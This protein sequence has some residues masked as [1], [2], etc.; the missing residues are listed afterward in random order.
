MRRGR[1]PYPDLLT[2]REQEVLELLRHG[3]TNQQIADRLGISMYG[4]RYHVSEIL[5]KLG[6]SSRE[7]AAACSV[8]DQR[9]RPGFAFA[10]LGWKSTAIAGGAFTAVVAALVFSVLLFRDSSTE[11]GKV[12]FI[13]DGSLWVKALPDGPERQL[14][15][16][17]G[18]MNPQ[19]SP[20]GEWVL[21][22]QGPP[23][24]PEDIGVFVMRSDGSEQR[25]LESNMASWSPVSD[26]LAISLT[27]SSL[28]VE[29]ADGTG[30]RQVLPPVPGRDFNPLDRRLRP[31]WSS[32]GQWLVFEEHHAD[33][34]RAAT[35]LYIGLRAVRVDGSDEHEVF[36]IGITPEGYSDGPRPGLRD[37]ISDIGVPAFV[38]LASPPTTSPAEADGLP[39]ALMSVAAV[40]TLRPDAAGA[41]AE[42]ESHEGPGA[43]MLLFRDAFAVSSD[44]DA[45][46][47]VEGVKLL[48]T[49]ISGDRTA[50]ADAQTDKA[51][52][53]MDLQTGAVTRL[54]SEDIVAVSPQWSPDGEMLAFVAR[55]D[56]GPVE[57]AGL[58]GD[59]AAERNRRLWTIRSDGSRAAPLTVDGAD[60]RHERP[61][62]SRD[63]KQLLFACLTGP[64]AED[65]SLWVVPARGGAA[66]EVVEEV[67]LLIA[68]GP[69]PAFPSR[70]GHI[71]WAN[72]Y[73]WWQP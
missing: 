43:Q 71:T 60:C 69:L 50:I 30:R 25:R 6:V 41:M 9:R 18:A 57:L 47:L 32:D 34:T 1:P 66:T 31:F 28:V 21:Y 52:S 48:D 2:P 15:F 67:S 42:L 59:G 51:I 46:A 5:S 61:M 4:A 24:L 73:D 55:P 8:R 13:R 53:V 22:Y 16:E 11:L 14:T 49:P 37:A 23:S 68:S 29:N 27:D 35:Y 70:Y 62:W 39:L 12:A 58:E 26:V 7:E 19:W 3:L 10:S 56:I 72:V 54:T 17:T 45:L 44:G 63:G 20:S 65:A 64:D 36:S 40:S 38:W 33:H